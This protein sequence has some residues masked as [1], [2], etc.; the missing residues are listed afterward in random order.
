MDPVAVDGSRGEGGGQIIRTALAL[1][2]ITGRPVS[3]RNI[4]YN[5]RIPG[6][7]P[8]HLAAARILRQMC[9]G[10]MKGDRAGSETLEFVPGRMRNSVISADV[11]TAGSI[12]LVLQ[13]A[14]PAA[15]VAGVRLDLAITGGTDVRWA[16]TADYIRLVMGAAY[17]RMG[18]RL[19]VD[20]QKRGYY[21]RGGGRIRA[22]VGVGDVIPAKLDA[23]PEGGISVIC[24]RWKADAEGGA[25]AI[26]EELEREG[27]P[28]TLEVREQE[29]PSQGA[30]VLAYRTGPGFA[31]GADSL[32]ADGFG[33]DVA[34]RLLDCASVDENLA[35]MLVVPASV[36][37]GLSIFEVRRT[38][39]HLETAL[40]VASL[41]TGCRYGI[42][43]TKGGIQVRIQGSRAA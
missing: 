4:R 13:A 9:D 32:Y 26:A 11:G 21:P 42:S 6:L 33:S 18:A 2:C 41:M 10:T 23:G 31:T 43:K 7:R 39:K 35:D 15:W 37:D 17:A 19:S 22:R 12:P 20:I 30:A 27:H 34:R 24:T 28:C 16:P 8:Q 36:A 40:Y 38:T 29:A 1:S 5:R 25:A 3:L 14:V